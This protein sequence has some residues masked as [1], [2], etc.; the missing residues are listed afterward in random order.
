MRTTARLSVLA[1]CVCCVVTWSAG[2]AAQI[3]KSP[4]YV[5][6]GEVVTY[7]EPGKSVTVQV[8]YR[9]H[10][11]RYVGD[12]KPGEKV[13]LTWATPSPGETDE[14][15][16][17]GHYASDSGAKW[18]YVLPAEFV[19]ADTA[20]RRLTCKVAIPPKALKVLK[21]LPKG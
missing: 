13:M 8:P 3:K 5:W 15:I 1:T 10:I 20:A 6:F 17:I 9:E 11:N 7:D 12:F 16:Y 18:G 14:I 2:L 21:E 19:S 4:T